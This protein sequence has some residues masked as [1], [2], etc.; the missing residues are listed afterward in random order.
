MADARLISTAF[1]GADAD[2][3]GP[4]GIASIDAEGY[5]FCLGT[6]E[7]GLWLLGV[8][9]GPPLGGAN[10][11]SASR[12]VTFRD[13][14]L[15]CCSCCAAGGEIGLSKSNFEPESCRMENWSRVGNL[16]DSSSPGPAA[17]LASR[18]AKGS[19][20]VTLA[21]DLLGF[22][23]CA[24]AAAAAAEAAAAGGCCCEVD[25]GLPRLIRSTSGM[26]CWCW[27]GGANTAPTTGVEPGF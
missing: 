7:D 1:S 18:A 3:A 17:D 27:V 4:D 23:R 13:I 14:S 6:S 5:T 8:C 19:P 26:T 21:G 11:S 16:D 22:P 15:G 12:S 24:T 10:A 25:G 2:F 20:F 9:A